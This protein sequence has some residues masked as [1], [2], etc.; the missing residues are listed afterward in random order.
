[1]SLL[2]G[3]LQFP[4]AAFACPAPQ[5]PCQSILNTESCYENLIQI[6]SL[7]YTNP[8]KAPISLRVKGE[9]FTGA[10]RPCVIQF[11]CTLCPISSTLPFPHSLLKSLTSLP[12]LQH[13]EDTA[14]FAA[15]IPLQMARWLLLPSFRSWF[16]CHLVSKAFPDHPI[17][18]HNP[19]L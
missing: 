12:P 13:P 15:A 18:N 3:L 9:G 7:L 1:M 14:A 8:P 17:W 4:F 19:S 6:L 2:L 11:H 10:P 16:T 5:R